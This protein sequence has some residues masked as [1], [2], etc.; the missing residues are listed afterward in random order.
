M[1]THWNGERYGQRWQ[2]QTTI[3]MIKRLLGSALAARRYWTQCREIT[4]RAIT[5]N[6]MILWRRKR[7]FLRS[8]A[9]RNFNSDWR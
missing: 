1:A 6:V 3:S 5:L 8:R 2:A 9:V 4:L 7:R